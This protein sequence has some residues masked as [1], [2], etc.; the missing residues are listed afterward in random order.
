MLVF[1]LRRKEK[2]ISGKEKSE[3]KGIRPW[4]IKDSSLWVYEE[5]KVGSEQWLVCDV[6]GEIGEGW[7]TDYES[8]SAA[9]NKVFGSS[10]VGKSNVNR[11]VEW[12]KF[13]L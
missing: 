6:Y 1:M 5:Y 7:R 12:L 4:Q 13:M 8:N 2:G 9:V 11:G 10:V 3:C